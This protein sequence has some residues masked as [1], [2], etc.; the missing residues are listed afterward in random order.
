MDSDGA[1][2][3]LVAPFCMLEFIELA[4]ALG[5]S[6]CIKSS[7]LANP[8]SAG[9]KVKGADVFLY[10]SQEAHSIAVNTA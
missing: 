6:A 5:H 3:F 9:A 8:V 1:T 10:R 7:S 2:I 4:D